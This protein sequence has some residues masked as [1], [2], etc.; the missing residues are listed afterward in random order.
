MVSGW[1]AAPLA[2]GWVQV[3]AGGWTEDGKTWYFEPDVRSGVKLTR[4][5]WRYGT[6][7][8]FVASRY[9]DV[10]DGQVDRSETGQSE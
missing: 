1:L 8:G 4:G 5:G 10:V 9:L 2:S 7:R 3:E 6:V